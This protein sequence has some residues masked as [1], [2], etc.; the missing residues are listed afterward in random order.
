[1]ISSHGFHPLPTWPSHHLVLRPVAGLQPVKLGAPLL[2]LV[3][4]CREM[5]TMPK[6]HSS[7]DDGREAARERFTPRRREGRVDTRQPD[8]ITRPSS[9]GSS[10]SPTVP[11][12]PSRF[13]I[14]NDSLPASS[15]PQ[16]P[17]HLPEARHQSR[18]R[19]SWTAP[20]R[21]RSP[22]PLRTPTTSRVRRLGRGGQVSPPGLQN[23]P[24]FT[25]LYGGIENTDDTVLL[26]AWRELASG[27]SQDAPPP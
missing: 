22:H 1:M 21:R 26:E 12:T 25:G 27:G 5:L 19:V 10:L 16:T 13:Q 11:R 2:C 9:A 17:Q 7:S 8:P 3:R 4:S 24:G 18:L 20:P 6:I 14:Y 23:P 15:Q